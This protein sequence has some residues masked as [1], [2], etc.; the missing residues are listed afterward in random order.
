MNMLDQSAST[1]SRVSVTAMFLCTVFLSFPAYGESSASPSRQAAV[2]LP[3]AT[4]KETSQAEAV[5]PEAAQRD[6]TQPD[7]EA[8][9]FDKMDLGYFKGYAYD[10]GKMIASPLKWESRDWLK[11]GMVVGGTSSLFLVD[12]EVNRFARKNQ[13]GVASKFSDVGNF[14]GEPKYLF[15]SVGAFYLYGFL[16]DDGKARRASLL[17]LE[18]LTISS[19]LSLGIKSLASRHRPDTGHSSTNWDGP[20]LKREHESFSS[21]HTSSAFAVATV[22]AAE[23]KDTP[24]VAPVAYGLAT[25]TAL[26]RIYSN[27]HWGSDV[28]FG[29][30][31]GHFVSKAVLSYHKKE[32]ENG[33]RLSVLPQV[34]KEMT[35]ITVNYKF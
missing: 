23:Y 15:P 28:F 32:H 21:G 10:T 33:N 30:A 1:V 11:F 29:A 18:S 6:A 3:E 27:E 17:A 8:A 2:L 31:L 35:G 24:Y 26:A 9:T 25:L 22:I 4:Q 34:G 20:S 13:S 12:K 14:I 19:A 5:Q 7:A 16:A